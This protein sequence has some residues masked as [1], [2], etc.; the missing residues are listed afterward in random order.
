MRL[1]DRVALITG[2]G[3]GLGKAFSFALAAEGAKIVVSDIDR[4]AGEETA[5]ALGRAGYEA[6]FIGSDVTNRA[7]VESMMQEAVERFGALDVLVNNAG[8][9]REGLI[10]EISFDDWDEVLNVHLNGTFNCCHFALRYMIAKNYGKIIN[11]SS[12]AAMGLVSH[13]NYAA[14]KSGINGLT[15][16][17]ALEVASRN[18]FVNAISPGW[19]QTDMTKGFSEEFQKERI[20]RIPVGRMGKP[21]DIAPLVVFLACDES[22]FMTGQ[23]LYVDG[24]MSVGFSGI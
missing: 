2:S 10:H 9:M 16:S 24:G 14:A 23:I 8:L 18:I 7:E 6:V 19:T 12:R 22:N 20:S 15:R 4:D 17:L 13:T 1:K 3:R 5:Q 11:I 21:E